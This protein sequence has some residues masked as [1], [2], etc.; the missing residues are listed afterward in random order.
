M[1]VTRAYLSVVN[2]NESKTMWMI[3][4]FLFLL[5]LTII[6]LVVFA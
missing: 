3:V 4:A 1:G 6:L 5:G 2:L